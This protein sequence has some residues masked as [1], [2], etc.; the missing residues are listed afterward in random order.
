MD[1][2]TLQKPDAFNDVKKQAEITH[3]ML[4]KNEVI[5]ILQTLEGMKKKLQMLIKT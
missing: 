2:A 4:K 3:V 5:E 1:N